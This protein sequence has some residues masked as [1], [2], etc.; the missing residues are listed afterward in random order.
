MTISGEGLFARL[1][2][3]REDVFRLC[4]GFSRNAAVAED[5][6]HDVFLKAFARAPSLREP[7]GIRIWLLRIARTTCLDHHRR[8]RLLPTVP[9]DSARDSASEG[10]GPEGLS[11]VN[12]ER[13]RLKAAIQALPRKHREILVLREYGG[14][15]YEDLARILHLRPGTVMSRLNRARKA[16]TAAF[17][18]DRP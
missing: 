13:A 8:L 7:A 12:E 6:C 18:G 9:T 5:L 14:L 15:S 2:A 11:E 16:V 3:Y 17:R 4:L 10:P 1:A